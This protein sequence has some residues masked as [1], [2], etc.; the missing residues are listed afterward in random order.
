M[1]K[2]AYILLCHKDPAA[3]EQ[4]ARQLTR[5]GDL[6]AI[7]FD[8]RAPRAD[9]RTLRAALEGNQRVTFAPRRIRCGW[10]EW[11][12]VEAT[13]LTLEAAAEAF[14][15][16]SHF[17]L[18][19]GD[20]MAIKTAEYAHRLLD[21]RDCDFIESVDFFES[22]WIK[23]GM[24]EDRL[25]YRH[26]FNERRNK[27]LFYASHALQKR[28]GV[29]RRIPEGLQMQI[30]SQW[31]CLRRRTVER[32]FDFLKQR[33][34]ITRFF[35]STWIP[36]ETFFQT[37]VRHLVAEEE[38]E[39]RTLTFLMF[40]DYGMPVTFYNDHYN[41]LLSQDF[42]FA[43]K[44]SPDAQDLKAR[45][46]ALYAAE[47]VEFPVSNEGRA[48]YDF[49]V[50][51]GRRGRRFA[52]RF[53][54]AESTLGHDR[55]LLLVICKKWH[56]AKRLLALLRDAAE[57]PAVEYLFDEEDTPLP[58][59]GGIEGAL[60]KRTRHRRALLRML[61]DYFGE[62]RLILCLDPSGMELMRDFTS[63]RAKVRLLHIECRFS[64][65]Y[66]KGHARRVGLAGA[67]TP[68][69]ALERLLP[70]I[71]ND[72]LHEAAQIEEAGFASL[73][74]LSEGGSPEEN[75]SQLAAF[76]GLPQ[77][78]AAA[79]VQAPGLFED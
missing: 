62:R 28:L 43:R 42:L 5:A 12:L 66:L 16:A 18:L 64:D 19:S 1:A 52:P 69:A 72:I 75:A 65:E 70:A 60:E 67:Q 40:S 55:E 4:Q 14:P 22:G 3:I 79:I 54:E 35:R 68:A 20:C 73:Y 74:R 38:I 36:D 31:W 9:Y 29:K 11:S 37:L 7:H 58:S 27:R 61:F 30:G 13:L 56:V 45:L 39:S 49:L 24:R 33:P 17:Y 6:V 46:G 77:E 78:R 48:L 32:I 41:L 76:L 8:G 71:R 26:V 23:T 34:D 57:T 53:W 15:G 10:G 25:I 59:L 51:L 2:I 21:A 63:D 50:Q 44:I 47:G